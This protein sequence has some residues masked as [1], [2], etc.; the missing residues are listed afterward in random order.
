[1]VCFIT[2]WPELWVGLYLPSKQFGLARILDL[3]YL[4]DAQADLRLYWSIRTNKAHLK[5]T[6]S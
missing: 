4:T 1:M 2:A 6:C 5:S 3:D